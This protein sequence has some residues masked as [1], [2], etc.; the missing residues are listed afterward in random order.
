MPS[1]FPSA[2]PVYVVHPLTAAQPF[3][4][5]LFFALLCGMAGLAAV[6]GLS[7][8]VSAVWT[9]AIVLPVGYGLFRALSFAVR[10]LD[11]RDFFSPLVAFPLAWIFWF[12]FGTVD[13]VDDP[14]HVLY[15]MF[16]PMPAA[17]WLYSALGLAGYL[18]GVV[19]AMKSHSWF[20]ARTDSKQLVENRWRPS[21]SRT[22]LSILF[23]LML[24][25]YGFIVRKIGL[26]VISASAAETRLDVAGTG[27]AQVVFLCSAWTIMSFLPAGYA[28]GRWRGK[29]A[30][31]GVAVTSVLLLSLGGRANFFLGFLSLLIAWNYLKRAIRVRALAFAVLTL[32]LAMSAYG[33]VRDQAYSSTDS[34]GYL[35]ALGIPGPVQPM[36]YAFTYVRGGVATFR[37]VTVIIP[38][39]IPYQHGRLTFLPL[40]TLLPGHHEMA[41]MFFKNILGHDFVG[42][43]QPATPLGPLYGDFGPPG[44]FAGMLSFGLLTGWLYRRMREQPT[45]GRVLVYAWVMQ[46]GLLGL[47]ASLF[48]YITTLFVPLLWVGVDRFFSLAPPRIGLRN[49]LGGGLE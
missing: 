28:A 14:W 11:S 42:L 9:V 2:R 18:A 29:V 31:A 19:L 12:T 25:T 48:P 37:D 22:G 41:D 16:D 5:L 40:A 32:F 1:G 49:Y 24:G 10:K 30:I 27:L 39:E 3:A 23:L 7:S 44:I 43:G 8:M 33:F 46:T 36:L 20:P 15:G 47:F 4:A 13:F 45:V 34:L 6:A 38:S 21:P 17:I 35:D 26:P